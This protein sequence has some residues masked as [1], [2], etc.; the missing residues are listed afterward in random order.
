MARLKR[1]TNTGNQRKLINDNCNLAK[2]F[3]YFLFNCNQY[4]RFRV[5]PMG[6][7]RLKG[8]HCAYQQAIQI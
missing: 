6:H 8:L 1:E 2:H 5:E 3:P 4:C 7:L